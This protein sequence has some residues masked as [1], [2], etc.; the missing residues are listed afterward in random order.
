MRLKKI[1]SVFLAAVLFITAFS[2]GFT[3][4]AAEIDYDA[5]YRLLANALKNEHVRELTNYTVTSTTLD[6]GTEGFDQEARGF[7]YD[8][9][10]VA[11]DN[12]NSDIL[13]ASN[14]FYYIAESLM[15]YKYGVGCYDADTLVSYVLEKIKPYFASTSGE[16]IYEDFYGNRFYPTEEEIAQYNNTVSL[17]EAAG[18][19]VSQ[20]TLTEYGIYFMEM[21]DWAYYNVETILKYFVG[22]VL[23]VNTGNWYHRFS[24]IVE[25]TVD[26]IL[27][28]CDGV[29]SIGKETLTL[30]K[31]VYQFSY[32]KVYNETKSKAYFSFKEPSIEEV[33]NNYGK[34][35]DDYKV[36]D[37]ATGTYVITSTPDDLTKPMDGFPGIL[38]DGQAANYLVKVGYDNETVKYLKKIKEDYD[39]FINV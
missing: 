38:R 5:Q 3:G 20:A 19:E 11:K 39:V 35:F 10:V 1:L 21:D 18:G 15:S 25:T 22:N 28:E 4:A 9:K 29:E 36:F 34:D 31:G 32:Q 13:K 23:K 2:I 14:R 16:K 33:W 8:H 12:T 17:I 7:A 27:E 24:F 26:N 6:N 30:R 37:E